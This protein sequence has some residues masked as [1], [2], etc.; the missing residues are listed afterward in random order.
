MLENI[1]GLW[2]NRT[3]HSDS[4]LYG[5]I[6]VGK[7]KINV[8]IFENRHPTRPNHPDY[9]VFKATRLKKSKAIKETPA[10]EEKEI[11]YRY[12]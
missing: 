1:G 12:G 9:N 3:R 5:V 10:R 2:T 8:V 6:Q 4:Y 11:E 7:K